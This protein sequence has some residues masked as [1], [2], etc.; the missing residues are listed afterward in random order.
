MNR[1]V[2]VFIG[3]LTFLINNPAFAVGQGE[4][5]ASFLKIAVGPRAVGM[6][7]AF[8]G[9]A[10]DVTAIYW[11]PA[12]LSQIN[13]RQFIFMHNLWFEDINH[14]FIGVTV[15]WKE[16]QVLGF[17]IIGLFIDNL[18]RR[19]DENDLIPI[20][21]FKATDQAFIISWADKD[22][23]ISIKLISQEIDDKKGTGLAFD[24]GWLHQ[25]REDIKIGLVLQNWNEMEELK[26]YKKKFNYPALIRTGIS[27][28]KDNLLLAIDLYKPFDNKLSI[29]LGL[30]KKI[31][32]KFLVRCG[33]RYKLKK[34]TNEFL[35]GITLGFGYKFKEVYQ[36]DYAYVPYQ[37]LGDT[38]RMSI[39]IRY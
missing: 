28:K 12:G 35:S 22:V 1:R 32:E 9:V 21:T 11:N 33:Y 17:G 39:M 30:E 6:G 34:I 38:H 20:G 2:L 31:Y 29:H 14:D 36:L 25:L 7:E 3:L 13:I 4:N 19:R 16:E 5:C 24:L 15:P 37:D 26:I 23:G 10:D 18:E 27:Y 8:V